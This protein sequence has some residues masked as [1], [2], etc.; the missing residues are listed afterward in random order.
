[1]KLSIVICT[2][3]RRALLA[4]ALGFINS[5]RRPADWTVD[6]V[7]IANACSDD[8]MAWL[9]DYDRIFPDGLT[10]TFEDE[11]TPGKSHALNR[12]LACVDADVVV[13]VDDDHRVAPEWLEAVTGAAEAHS[14]ILCFCGR[15]LPDWEGTEPGWVHDDGPYR[16][17]PYPVPRFDLGATPCLITID[18][19]LPGGGNLFFRRALLDVVGGF[20]PSLGPR[21][22]NLAGG[23]DVAFVV[24]VL[25]AGL[26]IRYV[27]GAL[28]YHYVD[29]DRLTWRY[30]VRKGY[31]RSRDL[32]CSTP[33][34]CGR[35]VGGVPV[36]LLP[37]LLVQLWRAAATLDTDRRRHFCVRS[38]VTLGEI[39]GYRRARKATARGGNG[40]LVK[41][42]S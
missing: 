20:D 34:P 5:A 25:S 26:A 9:S 27:P 35:Q 10:L 12:A 19:F 28:Q 22:H 29:P 7:V 14:D 24:R 38:A 37:Q 39:H 31:Q 23:E 33:A 21:G 11:P 32:R 3:N 6:L 13:F 8:T 30:I 2:H 4:R 36:Y 15:I 1:M 16:I 40:D 42:R 18:G 41:G 17:R